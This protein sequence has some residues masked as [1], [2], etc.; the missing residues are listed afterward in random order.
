MN[1]LYVTPYVPS[2]IRTRPYHLIRSLL[3]LGHS[4]TLV[5]AAKT[6][7]RHQT[8]LEHL[9]AWGIQVESFPV[10]RTRSLANCVRAIPTLQPFQAVYEYHPEMEASL[11]RLLS[12]RHYDIVHIEHL[13]ASRLVRAIKRAPAI[14]DSVDSISLLF[15]QTMRTT[16]QLKSRF[17]AWLDLARTQHYEARLLVRYA[18]I[19]V[20]SQRDKTALEDLARR[21]LSPD[22]KLA[23]VTVITNGVDLDYFHPQDVRRNG[24]TIVFTGKMSYHANV[25]AALHFAQHV[26]PHVWA[27]YPEARFQIVGQDPPSTLQQLGADSR[28]DVTGYVEDLRPYLAG[29]TVAVCPMLYAVGVQNKVL[30][31][32]AMGTPVVSSLAASAGI[33]AQSGQEMLIAETDE[34]MAQAILDVIERPLLA[35][36]LS[37]S[38]QRYVETHHSWTASAEKFVR[39]YDQA[40]AESRFPLSEPERVAPATCQR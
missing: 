6:S 32:M 2:R 3:D 12:T 26:L 21:H 18:Q 31:A 11:D 28:I 1:I 19:A 40:I 15:E 22:A 27:R 17:R 10:S 39:L 38:G 29:A 20:T 35:A 24:R 33:S 5:T 34:Q 4:L 25:A 14:Y 36:Q 37:E 8:E 13:R 9:A 23:P 7:P 30:E 16:H